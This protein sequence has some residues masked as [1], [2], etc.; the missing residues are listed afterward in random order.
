MPLAR[1]GVGSGAPDCGADPTSDFGAAADDD[2]TQGSLGETNCALRNQLPQISNLRAYI[3]E[4]VGWFDGFSTSGSIDASGGLGRIAATF[5][6]FTPSTSGLVD[7]LNPLDT[8]IGEL[9][10]GANLDILDA[11]NNNRCPGS[12]ERDP[13]DGSTPF[14]GDGAE[15]CNPEQVPTGP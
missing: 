4:L 15:G 6:A 11:N 13:G 3:P 2:F 12:L 7:L 8:D 1:A 14:D 5:N 9:L 10:Q